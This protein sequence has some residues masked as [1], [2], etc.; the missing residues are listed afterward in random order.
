MLPDDQKQ[1]HLARVMKIV[2]EP[3][4]SSSYSAV[5]APHPS[6]APSTSAPVATSAA[7]GKTADSSS[8]EGRKE[9]FGYEDEDESEEEGRKEEDDGWEVPKK[10]VGG[11]NASSFASA[12]ATSRGQSCESIRKFFRTPLTDAGYPRHFCSTFGPYAQPILSLDRL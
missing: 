6:D 11:S 3:T 2:P 12:A 7:Q 8:D 4:S 5:A 10:F 9:E 1:P